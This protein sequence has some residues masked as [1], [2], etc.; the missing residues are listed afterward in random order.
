MRG[1]GA[2]LLRPQGLRAVGGIA[3][4]QCLACGHQTDAGPRVYVCPKCGENTEVV[5]APRKISREFKIPR[6]AGQAR[7]IELLPIKDAASLPPVPVGPTPLLR[8]DRIAKDLGIREVYVKDDGRLPSASFKDRASAVALARA[9][10]L[11]ITEICG[12]S[13]GNAAAAT[14][15]LGASMGLYPYIFVPKTAPKAKIAQLVTFG[16]KVFLVDGNYDAACDLSLAATNEFGWYN[17]NTGFNPYTREGKKTVSFEILEDLEWRVPDWVIVSVGDGNIISGVARG[18]RDALEQGW[19]DRLP[20]LIAAQSE[21]SRSVADAFFGDGTIRPVHAT[22]IADSISVDLPRD[23]VAAVKAIRESGGR[24]VLVTDEEI[25]D[26]QPYLARNSGVF[27]EPAG[28]CAAAA[29]R[30]AAKDGVIAANDTVVVI[31]T[32]SGL[33][34]VDAVTRRLPDLPIVAPDIQSLKRALGNI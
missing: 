4:L 27:T 10:E 11:G 15:C 34:D 14:A 33:K 24:P 17:R 30:R 31:A 18:F 3:G 20:K 1:R 23:G 13:T 9:K 12:A 26:A 21:K 2:G 5:Y 25:L 7:Y 22:T 16:A 19:I 28:A 8:T 6:A 29:L 32:G